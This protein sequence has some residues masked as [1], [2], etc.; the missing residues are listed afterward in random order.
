MTSRLL[1]VAHGCRVD[2]VRVWWAGWWFADL[3][4]K[5]GPRGR[6]DS[7]ASAIADLLE[8]L[9]GNQAAQPK[10]H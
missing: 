3:E 1:T 2:L 4:G 9:S 5:P 7:E 6:G 8:K 10:G